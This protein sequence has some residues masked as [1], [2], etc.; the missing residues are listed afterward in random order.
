MTDTDPTSATDAPTGTE[1]DTATDTAAD[2]PAD[3]AA[4][5][6]GDPSA[7]QPDRPTVLYPI[8][9]L[10]GESL[11]VGIA[12]VLANAHVVLA[13]YHVIPEQTAADQAREQ[14]GERAM[15]KLEEF[16]ATLADAGATVDVHLVFTH[17]AQTTIDRLIY[18]HGSLA[19]LVPNGADALESVLLAVRGEVGLERNARLA[20]G[21]F[22]STDATLTLYHAIG[23]DETEAEGESLL[24]STVTALVDRG[25]RPEAIDT[26]LDR[27]DA[28]FDAIARHAADHDAVVMGETDPSVTTFVFGMPAEQ[29]AERFLGPVFVVQRERPGEEQ[30]AADHPD[31]DQSGEG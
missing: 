16:A 19:V 20:A 10:E 24:D 15:A 1:A 30:S 12:D 29:I 23:G 6:D 14:F 5:V 13:G 8:Q 26:I 31:G 11:P 3:T 25:V 22:A 9:V 7:D 27:P 21:L 28:P 4:D 2:T 17:E 18:E